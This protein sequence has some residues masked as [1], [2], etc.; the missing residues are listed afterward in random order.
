MVQLDIRIICNEVS[1]IPVEKME[2]YRLE[3]DVIRCQQTYIQGMVI[4]N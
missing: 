3:D 2:K 4:M 1:Y